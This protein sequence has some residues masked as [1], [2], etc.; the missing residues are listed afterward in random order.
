MAFTVVPEAWAQKK[1]DT[2]LGEIKIHTRRNRTGD[3]R[4]NEFAPGQ[5]ITTIDSATLQQYQLQSLG[6]MLAQ[7]V[8]VFMKAY[9]FNGLATLNFRG[10]SAAQSQVLWNGVPIQNAALGVADVSAL[11]VLLMNKV[12]V[13]YGGSAAL[14][15]SGNV[16]GALLLESDAPV[17]DSGGRALS[18]NAGVGSFGQYM[19]GAKGSVSRRNWYVSAMAFGQMAQNNYPY[20]NDTGGSTRMANSRLQSGAAMVHGAYK[21]APGNVV[22]L[23]AW[24]QQYDR[25]IPPAL[26]EPYSD[27]RQA[28]GSL[29]L[30]ADWH[31]KKNGSEWYA[32]ASLIR[33]EMNYSYEAVKL[34]WDF[35]TYQYYQEVGWRKQLS[36]YGQLLVFAPLQCSW[37]T[38]PDSSVK[39]QQNRAALAAAY[40]IK[41]FRNRMDIAVNA[42]GEVIN[43]KSIFLPGASASFAIVRWLSVR[44]NVQRTYRAPTLNELYYY[45]GGNRLLKPEQGWCEDAGYSI[46]AKIGKLSVQQDVSVYNRN[47]RDWIMWLGGAVWTPHNIAE[48]HSRGI[49]TENNLSY[50]AGRWKIHL[51]VN[52]SYVLATTVNSYL[53]NDG[54]VGRQ[55][56]Y[57]PRYNGQLNAGFTFGGFSFNYNHTYTG[58]RFI[59]TD[60]SSWITP[61]ETGNI[62]LMY[63]TALRGHNMQL[64]G[65]CNN[66]YNRRYQVVNGRPMPGINWQLGIKYMIF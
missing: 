6:N 65:Q 52:T 66:I 17:F 45:P 14:L 53:Y 18:V 3:V 55:I 8:P 37:I 56:P 31:R 38:Q 64:T 9:G 43:D 19:A 27:K 33:D 49:E 15:G 59:T 60:E 63:T 44:A 2:T 25:Q 34:H 48:V 1:K 46:R 61:Y 12:N 16:G 28:D 40:D 32:K 30:L 20:I 62:Q 39:G 22:G 11:P 7:Q 24:Y 13:L 50:A 29:R 58:Y 35:I 41:L 57:A 36:K 26:F 42:R 4:V 54:S 51:G 23:T 47:I 10:S 21:I 5:K